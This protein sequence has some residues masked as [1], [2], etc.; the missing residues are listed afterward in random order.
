MRGLLA[1]DSCSADVTVKVLEDHVQVARD[2]AIVRSRLS[3]VIA[4]IKLS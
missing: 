1:V 2:S 3:E 4:S